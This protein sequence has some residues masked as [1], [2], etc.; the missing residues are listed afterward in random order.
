T[1]LDE[2]AFVGG[3]ATCN[4][5]CDGWDTAAC[6]I[7]APGATRDCAEFDPMAYTGGQAVCNAEGLGWDET[8]CAFC[9][10]G[11][12]NGNEVCDPSDE[13]LPSATCADLGFSGVND[14]ALV[15]SC[16]ANCTWDTGAAG[17]SRCPGSQCLQGGS[18]NGSACNEMECG[19]GTCSI[20]CGYEQTVCDG[21]VCGSGASCQ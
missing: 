14:S 8:S 16:H 1:A 17:C 20:N 4:D 15:G 9:G 6:Q 12:T 13:S 7:C 18:C 2:L 21:V 3:T 19:G 5:S 11:A 10:D